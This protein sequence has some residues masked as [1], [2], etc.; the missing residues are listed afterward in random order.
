M[1]NPW[2][3]SVSY[4]HQWYR[5]INSKQIGTLC[6]WH[7]SSSEKQVYFRKN[8]NNNRARKWFNTQLSLNI[9]NTEKNIFMVCIHSFSLLVDVTLLVCVIN[10]NCVFHI[11]Q[12]KGPAVLKRMISAANWN[13]NC[14]Y[15][16]HNVGKIN[17][18][19]VD[20]KYP[21]FNISYLLDQLAK[22]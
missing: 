5:V 16:N 11:V 17:E 14:Y 12:K 9:S 8:T 1:F 19:T 6:W 7:N 15:Y 21:L 3:S 22:C 20:D 13:Y 10:I 4:V 2:T 18:L